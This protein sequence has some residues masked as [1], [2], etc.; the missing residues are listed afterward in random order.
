MTREQQAQH[1]VICADDYGISPAVSR[2]IRELIAAERVT[3]TSVMTLSPFWKSEAKAL[4]ELAE[5][6]DI[7]VHLTLT[8]QSPI[9]EMPTL[10]PNGKL[11]SPAQLARRAFAGLISREEV[12][13]E[14]ERQIDAFE[15]ALGRPPDHLDG[16]HHIQQLPFI[17]EAFFEVAR[18][19]LPPHGYVRLCIDT[20]QRILARPTMRWKGGFLHL[21]GRRLILK[22][23]RAGL[24]TNSGFVGFYPYSNPRLDIAEMFRH[25]L[26]TAVPDTILM[27]HP[28]YIDD[29]LRRADSLV[30]GRERELEY[31]AGDQFAV[32]LAEACLRPARLVADGPHRTTDKR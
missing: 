17:A 27:C 11:L 32:A 4:I 24:R 5:L 30:L 15:A 26:V 10:A 20:L 9:G 23:D 8:D 16:H 21:M 25:F 13:F 29:E 14:F 2:G 28:G 22:A 18:R 7:G 6:A 3:A 12:R 1:I 19:R 31:L